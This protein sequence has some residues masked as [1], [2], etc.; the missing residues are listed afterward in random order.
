VVVG[1]PAITGRYQGPLIFHC[2]AP[3]IYL[4]NALIDYLVFAVFVV[5]VFALL[6][7]VVWRVAD[8][9]CDGGFLLPI[10]AFGVSRSE[11]RWLL[12]FRH[13]QRVDEA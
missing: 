5:V 8:D 2:F 4:T 3:V 1:H 6:P 7:D 12:G 10:D 11:Q 9:H 13:I